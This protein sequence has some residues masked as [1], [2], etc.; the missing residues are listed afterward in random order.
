[1]SATDRDH[2]PEAE[3]RSGYDF[4]LGKWIWLRG[5]GKPGSIIALA[6]VLF[7]AVFMSSNLGTLTS[8]FERIA[9]HLNIPWG[10]T[11]S[12]LPARQQTQ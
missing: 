1:M 10:S 12:S 8:G 3:H 9:S 2:E 7:C 11:S 4:R 5:S 6:M